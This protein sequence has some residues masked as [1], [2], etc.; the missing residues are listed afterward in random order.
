MFSPLNSAIAASHAQLPED[1]TTKRPSLLI[2]TSP[3]WFISTFDH[4]TSMMEIPEKEEK[5]CSSYFWPNPNAS[6]S[7]TSKVSPKTR[8]HHRRHQTCG[9]PTPVR[10]PFLRRSSRPGE[11]WQLGAA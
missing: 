6:S 1:I 8:P 9:R 5:N 2:I 7:W 4:Q 3:S 11:Q 10:Q